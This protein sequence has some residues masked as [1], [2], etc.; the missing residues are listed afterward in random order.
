MFPFS[1][2]QR[3]RFGETDAAGMVYYA[4]YLLYAEVGRMGYLRALGVDRE[5]DLLAQGVDFLIGEASV[6]YR[7]PLH[8]D[9]E[10]DVKVRLGEIRGPSFALEYR[11]DRADGTQCA[12]MSTTQVIIDG[13]TRRAAPIPPALRATLEAAK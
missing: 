8:F 12:T 11:V 10:F 3:V 2:R 7:A 13:T 6:R 5:R 4:N 1:I 9:E